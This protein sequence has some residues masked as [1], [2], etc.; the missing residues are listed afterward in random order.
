MFDVGFWELTVIGVVALIIVGP[1]RL[2]GL[3]RTA[4]LWIGKGRRMIADVKRDI[5]REIKASEMNEL[6]D[7]K[8]GL[9]S[10]RKEV[11]KAANN[12]RKESGA[13]EVSGSLKEAFKDAAPVGEELASELKDIDAAGK[14]LAAED[15]SA[16]RVSA[17][18]VSG[19]SVSGESGGQGEAA[20][21]ETGA[22]DTSKAA[23]KSS[24]A[25]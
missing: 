21:G 22:T 9:D 3:A 16:S 5:D 13:E 15:G 10:V 8:E 6:K 2:P 20:A 23:G 14:K 19:E 24:P 11:D 7:V 25:Q 12:L 4:G 17:D 1:E 18:N